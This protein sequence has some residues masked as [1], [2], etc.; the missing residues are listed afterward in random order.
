METLLRL[1]EKANIVAGSIKPVA[2]EACVAALA[3]TEGNTPR[4]TVVV[5]KA[6]HYAVSSNYWISYLSSN[7]VGLR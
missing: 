7:E 4:K 1:K 3:G 6:K 2:W 5:C